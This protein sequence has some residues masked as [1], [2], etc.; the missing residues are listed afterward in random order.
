MSCALMYFRSDTSCIALS[1]VQRLF[2]DMLVAMEKPM[3]EATA[4]PVAVCT[5]WPTWLI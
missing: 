5:A 1:R 2:K 4:A 3:D